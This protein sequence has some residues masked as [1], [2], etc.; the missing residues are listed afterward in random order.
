MSEWT[1][2]RKCEDCGKKFSLSDHGD[3]NARALAESLE[4]ENRSYDKKI[5]YFLRDK[6]PE[7]YKKFLVGF[8]A[9]EATRQAEERKNKKSWQ[10]WK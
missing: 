4:S 6:C 9:Q 2:E 3:T 7:C 10:F 8:I 1:M 5:N